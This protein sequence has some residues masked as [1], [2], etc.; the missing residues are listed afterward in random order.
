MNTAMKIFQFPVTNQQ[1][2]T[3][4]RDGEPWLVA[5]DITEALGFSRSRNALRMVD[6]EDK[7]AHKVSTPGGERNFR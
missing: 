7:G 2:R 1:I 4:M 5:V 6:D 3:V